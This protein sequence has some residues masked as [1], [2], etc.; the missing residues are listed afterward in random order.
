MLDNSGVIPTKGFASG[1]V[2]HCPTTA[3]TKT[4]NAVPTIV[5]ASFWNLR[6]HKLKIKVVLVLSMIVG[7][8]KDMGKLQASTPIHV[9][10]QFR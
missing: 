7:R 2:G 10:R 4:T 3:T 8:A 5:S 9:S 1:A 6:I